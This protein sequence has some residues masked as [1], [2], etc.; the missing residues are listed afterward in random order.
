MIRSVVIFCV[1]LLSGAT[2]LQ[3]APPQLV[4]VSPL[5][6]APGKTVDFTLH[7]KQLLQSQKLWTTFAART[8]FAAAEDENSK[9]GEKLLCHVTVPR[10][11]QVGIY[12][13]RAVT[14]GGVSNPILLMVDDLRSVSEAADNHSPDKAQ[15]LDLP[16]AVDGQCD[17]VKVDMFR[18]FVLAGQRLSF[19]V[20]S[21]RLGSKLDSVLRLMTSRGEEIVRVDDTQGT[22]GDSR[23]SYTFETEGEYLITIE[24]VR[25]LGGAGFHY[26]LRIGEFPLI[27]AVYP[28]GGKCGE[29]SSFQLL[30]NT[31]DLFSPLHVA[32]PKVSESSLVSFGVKNDPQG[33]TGWFQ[34]E[35]N[36]G[37]QSLEQEPND[38]LKEATVVA[39]PGVINGRLEKPGDRDHFRFQA[40][41]GQ[42]L[43]CVAKTR[44]L[45][46]PCDLY[47]SL[48]KTDGSRI[49]LA[50]QARDT[51]LD[52]LIPEDGEYVLR[53]EDLLSGGSPEHIYRL[54]MKDAFFG[55]E[56]HAEK[57]EY[58]AP[59][60]GTVVVK[61]LAKR[62]GFTGPLELTVEGLGSGVVLENNKLEGAE[63][64]LKITL[65]A[66]LPQ[67]AM[68]LI[69]IVG[70]AKEGEQFYKVAA[71]QREPLLALFPS[72]F[73]LPTS[74]VE[75]IA[76][77]V[78][79]PIAPYF[80]LA[81]PGNKVCFP[82]LVGTSTFDIE[83][84]RI[85]EAFKA[86]VA[87]AVNGLP[88]GVTAEIKPVEKGL[89]AYRVTLKGPPEI[90]FG[91]FPISIVGTGK[92]QEQTK[93]VTLENIALQIT[94]PLVVQMTLPS[95]L[96][97]GSSQEAEI[98]LHRFGAE[99]QP[100]RVH[101]SDGPA[102]LSA[103]IFV[104][105]PSDAN[106]ATLRLSAA[107]D[108]P[109]GKFE[110]LTVV[111]STTVQGQNIVVQSE[112]V[113]GEIQASPSAKP[114]A[115]APTKT[116]DKPPTEESPSS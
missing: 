53:V 66:G 106:Q 65:P 25:H 45:G 99:P 30:G 15:L 72:T 68:R 12:A 39:F 18:F 100:V 43:H 95:P 59:L 77:G 50:P 44:E 28:A 29:V 17:S 67:G 32:L 5:A 7:G 87:L 107:A 105:V 35:T 41:K 88:E 70:K 4:R 74:L 93:V 23:F 79:P 38:E 81:V 101:V 57:N 47:L 108:A 1:T 19:E 89:K 82:Q 76:L 33:G 98:T 49:A 13:M 21:Q 11:E 14:T 97:A 112:P 52:M 69:K 80:E 55:F 91:S 20:V 6:V 51:V 104:T 86:E 85:N 64:L 54:D 27:T 75:T 116:P 34:V 103:P 31:T 37:S 71:K 92:F 83:I 84:K 60:G 46:S 22:G 113:A 24:D 115:E 9:K 114:P 73:S 36:P 40:T 2:F 56:L 96:V 62:T 109:P 63:T 110:N 3:A 90:A 111:A 48:H 26:R 61:V 8:D 58:V 16:L 94:K 42:R 102:G 10:D 78:G